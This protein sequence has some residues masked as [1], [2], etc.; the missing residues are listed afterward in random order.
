[1]LP[2]VWYKNIL[3]LT[4]VKCMTMQKYLNTY[5]TSSSLAAEELHL[6]SLSLLPLASLLYVSNS[7]RNFIWGPSTGTRC[8]A[9]LSVKHN[10]LSLSTSHSTWSKKYKQINKCQK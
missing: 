2:I 7:F 3:I 6:Q 9:A 4:T 5:M 10:K 8:S 1:M